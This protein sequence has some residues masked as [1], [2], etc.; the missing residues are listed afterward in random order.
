[1]IKILSIDRSGLISSFRKK[2]GKNIWSKN[3]FTKIDQYFI[4]NSNVLIVTTEDKIIEISLDSGTVIKTSKTTKPITSV[5]A[6]TD[7][8]LVWGNSIGEI[9]F[10]STDRN[11]IL[12]KVR[13]GGNISSLSETRHSVIATSFDNFVYSLSK[14]NGKIIWKK[15]VSSRITEEPTIFEDYAVIVSSGNSIATVIDIHNGRSINQISLGNNDFFISSP[16]LTKNILVFHTFLGI[17]AFASGDCSNKKS[18]S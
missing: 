2:N 9:F 10:V 7:N 4:S 17:S 13:T 1:M 18:K 3:F 5:I 15:R 14:K 16:I 12:W 11:K 6:T 8:N